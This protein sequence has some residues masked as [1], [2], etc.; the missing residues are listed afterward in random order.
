MTSEKQTLEERASN[1]SQRPQSDVFKKFIGEDWGPRP[2]AP[3]RNESADYTAVRRVTLGRQFLG[4]RLV[5]PAGNLKIRVNDTDYRFRAHSSFIYLTGLSGE[6]E[7]GAVLVLHPLPNATSS[8][9]E[10]HESVF[11]F[12]PRAS[13]ASEEFYADSRHGEFWVG[14]RA[15]AADMEIATGIKVAHIDSLRTDLAAN[16]G[17]VPI[18]VLANSDPEI[19]A[20]VAELRSQAGLTTDATEANAELVQALAEQRLIKDEYEISQTYTAIEATFAGFNR[21]LEAMP[22]ALQ[23]RRGERVLEGAFVANAR[24]EG[25]GVAFET[26]VAAGNNANTLH[27]IA[28]DSPVND[29]DLVLIDAGVEVDSLYNGDITRTFP[30]SG[31]FSETQREVYDVVL[32]AAEATYAVAR[33]PGSRFKDLHAAAMEVFAKHLANWGMLPVSAEES[34]KPENQYHRRWMPH[35]TSHHLGLDVHDGAQARRERYQDAVLEPGMIFTIEPG[36][37]FRADDLKI[38]ERFRGI[39][40]RI[41]DN[42]LITTDGAVRMSEQIPRTADDVEAWMARLAQ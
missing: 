14:A 6:D 12:H 35:G 34:L 19:E 4:E 37:Y 33:T 18:R 32:E 26:I 28:N 27:W 38:P 16:L 42:I 15:S 21:V 25:N 2:P 7:P 3:K 30:A 29:G 20:L 8:S 41:E 1:R 40:V 24:E 31:T 9:A 36:L 39:G 11:Y 5:I 23:H 22:R 13:R 10:T 17:T